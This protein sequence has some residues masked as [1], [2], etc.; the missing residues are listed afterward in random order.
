MKEYSGGIPRVWTRTILSARYRLA[1]WYVTT[2]MPARYEPWFCMAQAIRFVLWIKNPI[3][4]KPLCHLKNSVSKL[5][6][7]IHRHQHSVFPHLWTRF[8]YWRG[9][10]ESIYYGQ[11]TDLQLTIARYANPNWVGCPANVPLNEQYP[12]AIGKST[13]MR[14]GSVIL[15]W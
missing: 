2:L 6:A 7:R 13:S 5:P 11:I 1:W 3:I 8:Y 10:F 12:Q 9:Q 15:I 4:A 14:N